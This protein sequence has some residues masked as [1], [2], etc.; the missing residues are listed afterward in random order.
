M[1]AVQTQEKIAKV[2]DGIDACLQSPECT[3]LQPEDLSSLQRTL[4]SVLG[5]VDAC[6]QSPECTYIRS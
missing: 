2:V 5:G 6:L 3:Y 4:D 1:N